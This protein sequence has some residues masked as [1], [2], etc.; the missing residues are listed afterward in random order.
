LPEWNRASPAPDV[1]HF[2]DFALFADD[3]C[4]ELSNRWRTW[5]PEGLDLL[6][7]PNGPK[8]RT[9]G[10]ARC[11]DLILLRA[12]AG[13]I[14]LTTELRLTDRVHSYRL[15]KKP[16]SWSFKNPRASHKHWRLAARQEIRASHAT[17]WR[18]DVAG[19][20]ASVDLQL[21]A[22]Q[23]HDWRSALDPLRRSPIGVVMPYP[24]G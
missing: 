24:L 8:A 11:P 5:V 22:R 15:L 12:A 2:A 10:V 17:A 21:L 7:Y 20:F 18:T 6:P 14:M 23:M 19:Y 1:V 13:R 3:V 9:I 4:L 16:P